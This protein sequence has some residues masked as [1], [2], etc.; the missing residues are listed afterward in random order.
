M[1][2]SL[3]EFYRRRSSAGDDNMVPLINI[4]FLLLIFFMVAGKINVDHARNIELPLA[5]PQTPATVHALNVVLDADGNIKL[6][7]VAVT[8]EALA[9]ELALR[10]ADNA[11]VS[12]ALQADARLQA[13]QLTPLMTVIRTAGIEKI[14][15]FTNVEEKT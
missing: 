12:V 13:R 2:K 14:R 3:P 1:N 8:A 15:L 7:G 4:V 6:N 11:G 5:K 9:A 10:L